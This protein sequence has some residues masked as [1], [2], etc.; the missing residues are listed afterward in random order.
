LYTADCLYGTQV[1]RPEAG[2]VLAVNG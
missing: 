2:I 1:L